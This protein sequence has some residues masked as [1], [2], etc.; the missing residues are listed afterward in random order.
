MGFPGMLSQPDIKIV[1]FILIQTGS[2]KDQFLRPFNVEVG[3]NQTNQL[4][5]VTNGGQ[6]LDIN[7]IEQVASQIIVPKAQTEGISHIPNGWDCRRFSFIMR[8]IEEPKFQQGSTVER[9]FY[10]YTDNSDA[11]KNYLDPQMRIYFNSEL[12]ISTTMRHN[13]QGIPLPHSRVLSASQIISPM[14]MAGPNTGTNGI[15]G[16]SIYLVR[17][18]DAFNYNH[19]VSTTQALARNGAIDGNVEEM[20]DTRSMSSLGGQF[21]LN[22]RYDNSASRYLQRALQGY[23][24]G[25]RESRD[26]HDGNVIGDSILTSATSRVKNQEMHQIDFFNILKEDC[27]YLEQSFVRYGDLCGVFSGLDSITQYTMDDGSSIRRLSTTQNVENWNGGEYHNIAPAMLAQVVPSIMMENFIRM[28]NFTVV[29]GNGYGEYFIDVNKN[30]VKM[31]TNN[32]PDD[33]VVFHI[34]EFKRRLVV[35]VLNYITQ[36]NQV[37]CSIGMDSNLLG[38]SVIDIALDSEPV[39]RY[40]APTFSDGLFTPVATRDID[41]RNNVCGHL[42]WLMQNTF[43]HTPQ[44]QGGHSPIVNQYGDPTLRRDPVQPQTAQQQKQF[45]GSGDDFASL[46]NGLL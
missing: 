38:E 22:N 43:D 31:V 46:A 16:D 11:T 45:S 14:D 37:Y 24:H 25:L 40:V 41:M 35:D 30:S 15:F 27:G 3:P 29:S 8:V 6:S 18:E 20:F 9:V 17:P 10:G 28:V 26:D 2:Y 42:G 23:E 12:T 13:P 7:N 39:T 34:N 19:D 21:K 1:E 32:M 36:N 5:E 4:L 33:R 44:N